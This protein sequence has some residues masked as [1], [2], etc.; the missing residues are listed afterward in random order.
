[1][2]NAI[3]DFFMLPQVD[4]SDDTTSGRHFDPPPPA[5]RVDTFLANSN[6]YLS[7]VN[8]L[9]STEVSYSR[10]MKPGI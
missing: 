6:L 4:H 5:Y 7:S 10:S 3:K 2:Y 9:K 1:M 8:F